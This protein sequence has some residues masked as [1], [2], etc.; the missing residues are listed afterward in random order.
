MMPNLSDQTKRASHPWLIEVPLCSP[1][2]AAGTPVQTKIGL[3]HSV[4]PVKDLLLDSN[5]AYQLTTV[6]SK[7]SAVDWLA[8]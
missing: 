3:R 5:I 2:P 6:R 1:G 7:L 8:K 4:S